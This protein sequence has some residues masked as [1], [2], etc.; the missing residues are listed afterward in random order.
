MSIRGQFNA[1][2][3]CDLEN[4]WT[5]QRGYLGGGSLGPRTDRLLSVASFGS[6]SARA[7]ERFDDV[8]DRVHENESTDYRYAWQG[9]PIPNFPDSL[10]TASAHIRCMDFE[11]DA[12]RVRAA[13]KPAG[14]TQDTLAK[15]AGLTHKSALAKMLN[16]GRKVEV[17]EAVKIYSLLGLKPEGA[18]GVQSVPVIGL[19]AAGAWREA[20]EMPGRRMTIPQGIA[21]P[22]AFAVEVI[23]DSMNL[24]IRDGGWIVVDPDQKVLQQN[25]CYLIQN[26][27]HEV[28]VKR[29]HSNPARFEPVSDSPEH[30]GFLVSECDFIVLGRAVWTGSAL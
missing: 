14:Y 1:A 4:D 30:K 15:A 3:L 28:T 22:R 23:G 16:G 24:L 17:G 9:G 21:S 18:I 8:M 6:E 12:E 13:I 27:N 19:A 5:M 11:F 7:S 26:G 20:I 25:R 10:E 29:Y 2:L